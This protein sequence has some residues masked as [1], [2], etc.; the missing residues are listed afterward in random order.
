[1]NSAQRIHY[2]TELYWRN[3]GNY[4]TFIVVDLD[5][6]YQLCLATPVLVEIKNKM[7]A[8]YFG[9]ELIPCPEQTCLA[10]PASNS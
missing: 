5:T 10:M 3:A 7:Q 4:P 1:M 9:A 8:T 6:V 2:L